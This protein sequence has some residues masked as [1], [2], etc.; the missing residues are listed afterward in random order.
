MCCVQDKRVCWIS[1]YY[2]F[3]NITVQVIVASFID[4]LQIALTCKIVVLWPSSNMGRVWIQHWFRKCLDTV[5]VQKMFGYSTGSGNV[6][7]QHWFRKCLDTVL[8]QEMFGYSTCSVNIWIQ[9]WFRKCLYTAP[10]QK[11]IG[12]STGSANV[13]IHH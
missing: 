4:R 8:V 1:H 3:H 10:V 2:H 5:L 11:I 13:W 7:I 12:Y 6:W 9:Y